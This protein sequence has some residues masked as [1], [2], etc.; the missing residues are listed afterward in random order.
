MSNVKKGMGAGVPAELQ[1]PGMTG[2]VKLPPNTIEN[3]IRGASGKAKMNFKH[4][5][6]G[7]EHHYEDGEMV[8]PAN[9]EDK[10][11][12]MGGKVGIKGDKGH[13]AA[14]TGRTGTIK[15]RSTSGAPGHTITGN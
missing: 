13:K 6:L 10:G 15:H 11:S 3:E 5:P 4:K 1:T 9:E 7:P 2:M 14:G 8:D 12:V